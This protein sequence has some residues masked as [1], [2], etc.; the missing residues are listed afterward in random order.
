M[1]TRK[2]S[3]QKL[4]KDASDAPDVHF[5]IVNIWV[6]NY[7]W[8]PIPSG[9]HM[10]RNFS[11]LTFVLLFHP[12]FLWG[13]LFLDLAWSMGAHHWT[14]HR[15][16]AVWFQFECLEIR[17]ISLCFRITSREISWHHVILWQVEGPAQPKITNSYFVVL[18]N[19]DVRRFDISVH[20]VGGVD[21]IQGGDALKQY[22]N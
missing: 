18:V 22:L 2:P 16:A 5:R 17:W 8:W 3:V 6:Q 11:F 7:F 14:L 12:D 9:Y 13:Y 4:R 19:K 15:N 21:E 1:L 20:H 10:H